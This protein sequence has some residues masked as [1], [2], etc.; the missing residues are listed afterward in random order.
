MISCGCVSRCF[1]D[2]FSKKYFWCVFRLSTQI[3][4]SSRD[5]HQPRSFLLCFC[6]FSS[7]FFIFSFE[8]WSIPIS[9]RKNLG[10]I[11]F[12]C[13]KIVIQIMDKTVV[14]S[15][16]I[17]ISLQIQCFLYCSVVPNLNNFGVFRAPDPF[18]LSFTASPIFGNRF[19][20]RIIN[21]LF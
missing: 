12:C 6:L 8:R 16:G 20:K 1:S 3:L 19:G 15:F 7:D 5:M 14:F 4:S 9:F 2:S 13:F 10:C 11:K 21:M 18:E 17:P